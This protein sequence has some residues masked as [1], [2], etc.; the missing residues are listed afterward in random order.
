[1]LTLAACSSDD[2]NSSDGNN[3]SNSGDTF[4]HT[5]GAAYPVTINTEFGEVTIDEQPERVV[6]VGWGDAEIAMQL[7]VQPVGASD[8]V[9]VNDETGLGEWVNESYDE[10]PV[11]LGTMDLSAEEVATLEP[12]LILDVRSSG[13][14]ER[15]DKLSAIAP[16]VGPAPGKGNY[17]TVGDEQ[18]E[19]IATAL[20]K[21]EEG[22]VILDDTEEAFASVK[23]A[24]PEWEGKTIS[25]A[26]RTSEGWGAY[27]DAVRVDFF[28]ELGFDL[29]PTIEDLE[30]EGQWSIDL[31]DEQLRLL[32]ADLIVAFPIY[33]PT[34]EITDN[35]AWKS[36]PAV[37][38]GHAIVLDGKISEAFSL[39]TPEAQKW[40]LEQLVPMIEEALGE[41]S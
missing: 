32:D 37:E 22:E 28:E 41:N 1:M 4:T 19:M 30:E 29:V 2:G 18:V 15:H 36:I 6:A 14:Q 38:D 3:S 7:G 34:T 33:I 5:E 11:L 23:E 9:E 20:G 39:G 26:T 40:A 24:H 10:N 21:S 8:W 25:V 13:E 17:L 31:S 27:T 16:T 35:T 12:D